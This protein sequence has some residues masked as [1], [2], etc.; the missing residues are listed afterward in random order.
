MNMVHICG[1]I[2]SEPDFRQFDSGKRKVSF[3]VA[4]NQY[5]KDSQ[6][7]DT[8]WIP[9]LA[10]DAVCDRFLRCREKAK[11]SGRKINVT[12]SFVQTKWTDP[13]SGKRQT[14]LMV[15]ILLFE[16]L[17]VASQEPL[18]EQSL[19]SNTQGTPS[20]EEVMFEGKPLN[21]PRQRT[22]SRSK[23]SS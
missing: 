21:Q 4:L 18:V 15:K 2:G 16:L 19:I 3:S 12:G 8:I 9:C 1:F 13:V 22:S 20:P 17:S 14:R 10:W 7:S 5:S 6:Q 23:L 11:L